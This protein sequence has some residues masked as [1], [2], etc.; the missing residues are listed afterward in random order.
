ML[1]ENKG[2]VRREM[3]EVSNH[4]DD[5]DAADEIYASDYIGHESST[6]DI[7]SIEGVKQFAAYREAFPDLETTIED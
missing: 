3:E 2:V 6:G 1:E 7:R 4:A 5:L